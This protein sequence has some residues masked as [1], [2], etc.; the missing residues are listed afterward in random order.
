MAMAPSTVAPAA[1]GP[2]TT[3]SWPPCWTG[4][5]TRIAFAAPTAAA[6][7]TSD[8]TPAAPGSTAAMTFIGKEEENIFPLFFAGNFLAPQ[9][10]FRAAANAAA[11]PSLPPPSL[12]LALS[13][14]AAAAAAKRGD[15]GGGRSA[16]FSS[17]PSA[18]PL[19]PLKAAAAQPVVQHDQKLSRKKV[20]RVIDA[21][22]PFHCVK[23]EVTFLFSFFFFSSLPQA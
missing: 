18:A 7:W 3:S 22:F 10:D 5:G 9:R 2:F 17:F 15:G 8:A 14:V 13:D 11:L 1:A 21:F 6:R 4:G 19:T 12:P 16:L 23:V 20:F